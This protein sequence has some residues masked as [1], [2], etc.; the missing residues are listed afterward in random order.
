MFKSVDF[1]MHYVVLGETQEQEDW[2]DPNA[3]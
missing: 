1:K 2:E 3:D